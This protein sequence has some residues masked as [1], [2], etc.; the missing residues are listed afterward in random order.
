M[1]KFNT[2]G[3]E[4][5]L[6]SME[7]LAELPEEVLQD[8]LLAGGEVVKEAHVGKL[9]SLGLVDSH[10]LERSITVNPKMKLA[11]NGGGVI[12]YVSVYPKGKREDQQYTHQFKRKR[13]GRTS[14]IRAVTNNDV[15]FI[16]EFG[17]PD[18][19]ILATQW[20]RM[21]NEES[22]GAAADAEERVYNAWVDGLG[23]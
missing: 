4:G 14:G 11:Q 1:A 16:N 2:T 12:R 9:R 15:A 17:A 8:M 13:K 10:Q 22:A 3:I 7:Q 5:L 18:R 19:H 23:L 21:A 20:M 6:L